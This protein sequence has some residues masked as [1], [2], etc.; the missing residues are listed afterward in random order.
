MRD[1][2]VGTGELRVVAATAHDALLLVRQVVSEH[3]GAEVGERLEMRA[4]P[5]PGDR[6]AEPGDDD[7]GELRWV[8]NPVT[9][10]EYAEAA[11]GRRLRILYVNGGAPISE[12]DVVESP[13]IVAIA[14]YER[15]LEGTYPDGSVVAHAAVAVAGCLQVELT[16]PVGKR[17]VVDGTT[18]R[19]A[20]RVER[21]GGVDDAC[22]LWV[23]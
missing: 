5:I 8:R 14:L 9:W 18:R 7:S 10:D 13:T 16:R 11:R 19:P 3:Y 15:T 1:D 4:E 2:G 6:G 12:V 21:A 20:E 23:P 17:R 22:P